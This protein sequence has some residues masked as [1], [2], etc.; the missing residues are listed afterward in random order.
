[1]PERGK[2]KAEKYI[3]NVFTDV[4]HGWKANIVEYWIPLKGGICF[5]FEAPGF[6][7]FESS[8]P[9][10]KIK[11]TH[12]KLLE[13]VD[14]SKDTEYHLKEFIELKDAA[15]MEERLVLRNLKDLPKNSRLS[16]DER[17]G[18]YRTVG[19]TG[20]TNAQNVE[21]MNIDFGDQNG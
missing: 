18:I 7:V 20:T 15:E 14:I 4:T 16:Y 9:R 1:M 21:P 19:E 5:N 13:V 2:M 8:E 10:Y 17:S 11:D 3:V 12:G 6:N